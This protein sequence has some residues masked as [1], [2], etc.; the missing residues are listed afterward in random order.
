M[1]F[2]LIAQIAKTFL[3]TSLLTYGNENTAGVVSKGLPLA[4]SDDMITLLHTQSS[5]ADDTFVKKCCQVT[6]HLFSFF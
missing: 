4:M 6:A 5:D 3:E 1:S 2:F